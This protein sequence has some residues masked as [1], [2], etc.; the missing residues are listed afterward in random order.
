VSSHIRGPVVEEKNTV[1]WEVSEASISGARVDYIEMMIPESMVVM[2]EFSRLM[3]V[4]LPPFKVIC[5]SS[6]TVTSEVG[7]R[8]QFPSYGE[9]LT[10]C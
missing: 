3:I 7:F 6:Q 10:F 8:L 5:F 1:S 4:S 9:G 2:D